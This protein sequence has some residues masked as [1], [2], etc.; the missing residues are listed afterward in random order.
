MGG[1]SRLFP[2]NFRESLNDFAN[3]FRRAQDP[4]VISNR[5][6]HTTA[7]QGSQLH[8]VDPSYQNVEVDSS[9]GI[10]L[11]KSGD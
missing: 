7:I 2:G 9:R 6:E 11:P 8:H 1:E 10:P 4:Q 5:K 3:D